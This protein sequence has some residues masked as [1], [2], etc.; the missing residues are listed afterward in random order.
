[1]GKAQGDVTTPLGAV[2]G[3]RVLVAPCFS[4]LLAHAL[5]L[6]APNVPTQVRIWAGQKEGRLRVCIQDNGIGVPSSHLDRIWRIFERGYHSTEYPGTGIGL[7]VVK[8][9]VERMGGSVGVESEL[10]Q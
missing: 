1:S 5:Q 3:S 2:L 10:G 9:A 4:N 8:R 7:S 6:R